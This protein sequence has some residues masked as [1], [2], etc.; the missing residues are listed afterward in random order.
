MAEEPANEIRPAITTMTLIIEPEGTLDAKAIFGVLPI[1]KAE[2]S[3]SKRRRRK[4]RA[5]EVVINAEEGAIVSVRWEY[6]VR[7]IRRYKKSSKKKAFR[8]SVTIDV[9]FGGNV[10]SLKL[11]DGK[12][13]LC[14]ATSGQQGE[15]SVRYV[16]DLIRKIQELLDWQA[17]NSREAGDVYRQLAADA[18]SWYPSAEGGT[19]PSTAPGPRPSTVSGARIAPSELT[20]LATPEGSARSDDSELSGE[21]SELAEGPGDAEGERD[22][23]AGA[24]PPGSPRFR[25]KSWAEWSSAAMLKR[26][27]GAELLYDFLLCRREELTPYE[28]FV[29]NLDW[30]RGLRRIYEGP[31]TVKRTSCS[32][33]NIHYPLGQ[34][35]DLHNLKCFIHNIEGTSFFAHYDQACEKFLNIEVRDTV[36]PGR[37]H[38][39]SAN[40]FHTFMVYRSGVVTQSGLGDERMG[41]MTRE[42][43]EMISDFWAS[44]WPAA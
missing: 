33:L 42:F 1:S 14:G 39:R 28:T 30:F 4:L 38:R 35:I 25:P 16:F 43:V 6:S 31:L 27:A 7:G 22:A 21:L 41:Q 12:I 18:R 3:T 19:G 13:Q 15:D 24:G 26:E 10:V 8:H 40:Y 2:V 17:A 29:L 20:E 9:F 36:P 23:V 44:G 32:M 5:S 34:E 37:F 11:P